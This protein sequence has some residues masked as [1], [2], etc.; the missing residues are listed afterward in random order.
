MTKETMLIK[1]E[2]M[3][4]ASDNFEKGGA[5]ELSLEIL[6]TIETL[7]MKPPTIR[8]PSERNKYMFVPVNIWE[9]EDE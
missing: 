3:L 7:G 6:D 5:P 4:V 2:E 1:L 9:E 8:V